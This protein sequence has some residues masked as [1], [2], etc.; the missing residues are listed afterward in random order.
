MVRC[1]SQPKKFDTEMTEL[2]WLTQ[3]AIPNFLLSSVNLSSQ[4]LPER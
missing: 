2:A 3:A 1:I 4:M